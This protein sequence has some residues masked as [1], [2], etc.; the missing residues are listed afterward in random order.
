MSVDHAHRNGEPWIEADHAVLSNPDMLV[1]EKAIALGRTYKATMRMCSKCGY[2]S[3]V[4]KGDPVRGQ[5]VIDNPNA[6][7]EESA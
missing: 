6:P 4:G 3:K 2:T 7:L 1:I 5:W